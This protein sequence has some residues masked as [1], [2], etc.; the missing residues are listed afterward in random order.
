MENLPAESITKKMWIR[1]A[2]CHYTIGICFQ[3]LREAG[4]AKAELV[5]AYEI[6]NSRARGEVS[7]K[8]IK[9]IEKL[10]KPSTV[11]TEK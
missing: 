2:L 5:K 4:N 8:L 11:R 1:L 10:I 6:I 3:Q 9:H 7:E